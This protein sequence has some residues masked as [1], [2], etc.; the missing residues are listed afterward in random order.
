MFGSVQVGRCHVVPWSRA[1]SLALTVPH[2]TAQ[3]CNLTD[4]THLNM[5]G[6]RI[7]EPLDTNS[8]DHLCVSP[9]ADD[10]FQ[11][12]Y[13]SDLLTKHLLLLLQVFTQCS[14]AHVNPL[15]TC[16]V[17]NRGGGPADRKNTSGTQSVAHLDLIDQGHSLEHGNVWLLN[18]QD[19]LERG[20]KEV[21]FLC[22][23]RT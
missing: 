15:T 4:Q 20:M 14:S 18:R 9:T 11:L 5:E 16:H 1:A 10:V 17:S 13:V 22:Q 21:M 7:D 23:R 3:Q 12:E 8:I 6:L 2:L 19:G